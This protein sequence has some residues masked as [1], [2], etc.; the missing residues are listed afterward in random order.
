MPITVQYQPPA[1]VIA[2]AAYTAGLGQFQQRQQQLAMQAQEAEQNRRLREQQMAMAM[3][4]RAV[5]NQRQMQNDM[6]RRQAMQQEAGL[7]DRRLQLDELRAQAYTD[8]TRQNDPAARQDALWTQNT[9]ESLEKQSNDLRAGFGKMSLTPEGKNVANSLVSKLRSIQATRAKVFPK[10]YAEYL[11]QWMDQV[12]KSGIEQM[13]APPPTP[14][15]LLQQRAKQL[16]D[17]S[18]MT[19]DDKGNPRLQ[20]APKSASAKTDDKSAAKLFNA[21]TGEPLSAQ[22]YY[23]SNFAEA[24]KAYAKK[25]AE[26]LQEH[27]AAAVSVSQGADGKT[28]VKHNTPK[29][30]EPAEVWKALDEEYRGLVEGLK[31]KKDSRP[32]LRPEHLLDPSKL[33]LG[34]GVGESMP[35]PAADDEVKTIWKFDPQRGWVQAR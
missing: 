30:V 28:S 1:G 4:D 18:W 19:F 9:V 17:G 8:Q 5:D 13:V 7:Q 10:Q 26:L 14:D 15:D 21:T 23:Q 29:P 33:G 20:A 6:L 27:K 3:Q 2:D 34:D 11:G 25:Y 35:M 31:P 12:N 22:E 16:P 32:S 24:Q